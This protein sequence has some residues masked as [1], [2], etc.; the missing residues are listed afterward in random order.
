MELFLPYSVT[1]S[2]L[3]VFTSSK[4][5]VCVL[6]ISFIFCLN[7]CISLCV[8]NIHFLK[9]TFTNTTIFVTIVAD[10]DGDD[11]RC[12]WAETSEECKDVCK[13]LPGAVLNQVSTTIND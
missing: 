1:F 9:L 13:A 8:V 12:R 4:T 6:I 11:V 5:C 3:F 2:E 7:H 10:I